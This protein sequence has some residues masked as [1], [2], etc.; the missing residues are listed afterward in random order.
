MVIA[1]LGV[2]VV[3]TQLT[4]DAELPVEVVGGVQPER[5]FAVLLE[6]LAAAEA[7]VAAAAAHLPAMGVGLFD[8]AGGAKFVI[9]VGIAALSA[10]GLRPSGG[11]G[12]HGGHQY[13]C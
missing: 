11:N 1:D 7:E 12:Q 2:A 13:R 9:G 4:G 6:V 5:D 10:R 8:L 3:A